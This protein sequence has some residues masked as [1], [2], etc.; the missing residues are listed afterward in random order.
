MSVPW[1]KRLSGRADVY[2]FPVTNGPLMLLHPNRAG[3]PIYGQPRPTVVMMQPPV[4]P[5]PPPVP[6]RPPVPPI[7]V[8]FWNAAQTCVNTCPEGTTGEP[9]SVTVPANEYSSEVSQEAANAAALAAACAEAAAL[10]EENPCVDAEPGSLWS[11]GS[12]DALT[13]GLGN[14]VNRQT[15]VLVGQDFEVEWLKIAAGRTFNAGLKEDGKIWV[16][17]TNFLGELGIGIVNVFPSTDANRPFPVQMGVDNWSDVSAGWFFGAAI[18]NDGTLYAWGD[19]QHGQLGQNDTTQRLSPTQV[20]SASNWVKVSCGDRFMFALNSDGELWACGRGTFGALGLGMIGDVLVLTQ[21]PGVWSDVAGGTESSSALK[22]DGTLWIVNELTGF[23]VQQGSD[24]DWASVFQGYF[25]TMSIKANGTLWAIGS[26]GFG[27]LGLG[28]LVQRFVLTQ[29]GSDTDWEAVACSRQVAPHTLAKKTGGTIWGCGNDSAGMLGQGSV[30][31]AR[32]TMVPIG[33]DNLWVGIAAGYFTSFGF[34]ST[35]TAPP[36]PAGTSGVAIGGALSIAGGY[37]I[38]ILDYSQNF[39]VLDGAGVLFD[40]LRVGGAGGGSA[41]AGGGGE[42]LVETGVSL[43]NGVYPV[44]IGAAGTQGGAETQGGDGG[45]TTFNGQSAIGGGG[46]G[47]YVEVGGAANG[48]DGASGGGAG[49]HL[50][51]LVQGTPGTGTA[52]NDGGTCAVTGVTIGTGGGGGS[53]AVGANG[54]GTGTGGAGGAGT[55]NSFGGSAAF[56]GAGGGGAGSVTSGAGGSSGA[57]GRGGDAASGHRASDG[58]TGC[59]GG[60]A[61]DVAGYGG[62]GIVIIRYL[63]PP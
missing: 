28:D 41:G 6:P 58:L 30:S 14:R 50:L 15:P 5:L 26:N 20:G 38:H 3:V 44:V 34:R 61:L 40:I 60:G 10:R 12:G 45:T 31:A 43:A 32:T 13:L 19:N 37:N 56:Y 21:V 52:G 9:I 51:R 29:V 35:L 49:G 54:V 24:T 36:P 33:P 39:E 4:A 18:K 57:G 16:W 46:G 17:G 8:I 55:S 22:P 59:G 42:V 23:F 25:Y 1:A 27:Q 48:R 53:A 2:G 47:A 7:T 63:T 62:R 11:W